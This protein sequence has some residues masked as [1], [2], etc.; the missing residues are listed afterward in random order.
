MKSLGRDG[1][2]TLQCM[3]HSGSAG[4]AS[5]SSEDQDCHI[6]AYEITS[7]RTYYTNRLSSAYKKPQNIRAASCRTLVGS[8]IAYV[9]VGPLQEM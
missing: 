8:H 9:E 4:V 6:A 1:T 7:M 5:C 3:A 2:R